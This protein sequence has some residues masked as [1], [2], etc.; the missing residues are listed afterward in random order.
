MKFIFHRRIKSTRPA[1]FTF[2]LL[3]SLLFSLNFASR[4]QTTAPLQLSLA[5]ILI[6]LRSKKVTLTERNTLLAEAVRTRG[7]TFALTPE[8]ERELVNTGADDELVW[9]IR[10]KSPA[11]K[12]SAVPQPAVLPAPQPTPIVIPT[13]LPTPTATPTATATPLPALDAVFYRTR[14]NAHI[15]KA[16]YELALADF[17]KAIELSPK[18]SMAYFNRGDSFERLGNFERAAEDYQKAFELDGNNEPAKNNW[19]RLQAKQTKTPPNPPTKETV[20]DS[21]AAAPS[22]ELGQLKGF[23][24]K[25]A[26]PI[27]PLNAKQLKIEGAVTVKITLDEEG[28]VTAAKAISGNLLLRVAGEDAALKSKFK[29]ARIGSRPVKA[30]GFIIY[31]FVR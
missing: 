27:Y 1:I 11:P 22:V 25:L 24:V 13:P 16:E 5:D 20:S 9:A 21:T 28:N 4:A 2:F 8:I 7:I 26:P 29:P 14:A 15:I 17:D 30:T 18:E 31:N 3:L 19:Q 6:A 12:I 23:A 10:Q